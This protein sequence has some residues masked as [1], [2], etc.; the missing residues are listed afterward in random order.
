[1][2]KKELSG[3][4]VQV[5]DDVSF[6]RNTPASYKI[7]GAGTVFITKDRDDKAVRNCAVLH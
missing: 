7:P 2:K 4:Q 6:G 5:F 1:M 3:L